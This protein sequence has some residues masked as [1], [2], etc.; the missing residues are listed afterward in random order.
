MPSSRDWE[1]VKSLVHEISTLQ[2]FIKICS[3]SN[4]NLV[5]NDI[6]KK[7]KVKYETYWGNYENTNYLVYVATVLDPC[8]KMN[9]LQYYF[10]GL[11]GANEA[12]VEDVL[13][14]LFNEYSLSIVNNESSTPIM[15]HNS[16]TGECSPDD[17]AY[18]YF[19]NF[20]DE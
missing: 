3:S 20:I 5:L 6:A 15:T 7:V 16:N 13:R 17:S 14:Q 2:N 8:L 9:F 1:V 4:D 19:K 12:K 10:T 18:F 11:F